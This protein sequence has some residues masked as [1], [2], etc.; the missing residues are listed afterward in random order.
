MTNEIILEN[1]KANQITIYTIKVEE[2]KSKPLQ[3]ITP[4]QLQYGSAPKD[5]IIVDLLR[6]ET[7][8]NIDGVIDAADRTK[9]RDIFES[10]GTFTMDYAG[11]TYVVN[12]EKISIIEIPEDAG[13]LN[14]E[15]FIV[16]FS[17]IEGVNY[18]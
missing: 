4:P 11:I 7:R 16:K 18:G 8:F 14:P 17:V 10:R 15:T 12:S 5:T 6:A 2:I 3:T 13:D 9:L 1:G